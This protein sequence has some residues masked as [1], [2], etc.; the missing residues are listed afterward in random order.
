MHTDISWAKV[1]GPEKQQAYFQETLAYINAERARGKII[2]PP[3]NNTF[4]ALRYTPLSEVKVVLLGRD[5]YH[6]PDQAHGLCFSVPKGVMPPPS[7]QNMFKELANTVPGFRYP[8]HG[9]LCSWASQGVLL[10]N[11]VLSVE[12]YQPHSHAH[13]GWELFTDRVIEAVDK[14][15]KSVVFLLWGKPAGLKAQRIDG[16]KH[17]ILKAPHPSPRSAHRGF[18]GCNHFN[19][20]NDYLITKGKAPIDWRLPD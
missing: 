1:L 10:L 20:A 8:S 7:L 3:K 5:P 19:R 4:N 9:N 13:I 6:D 15:T 12:R 14:Y 18:F 2:Y 11:T 17:L 16:S